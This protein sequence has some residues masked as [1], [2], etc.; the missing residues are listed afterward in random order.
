MPGSFAWQMKPAALESSEA[1]GSLKLAKVF[2]KIRGPAHAR[3]R[4]VWM[5][6]AEDFCVQGLPRERD[7]RAGGLG[8]PTI[9]IISAVSNQGKSGMGSLGANLMFSA[10]FQSQPQFGN[11]P[12]AAGD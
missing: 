1:Q 3:A 8:S 2:G 6:E 7:A 9:R 10:S 4:L 11:R 12:R 5:F